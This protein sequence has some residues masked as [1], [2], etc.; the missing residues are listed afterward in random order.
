[1]ANRI[2]PNN[3]VVGQRFGKLVV[4]VAPPTQKITEDCLCQCE[5]G[6]VKKFRV[7]NLIGGMSTSCGCTHSG[8]RSCN[9]LGRKFGRLTVVGQSFRQG[10]RRVWPCSCE[11]G[12][13]AYVITNKLLSGWTH[14][15]GCLS[16]EITSHINL[17][18]GCAKNGN[19]TPEYRLWL[20]AKRRAQQ[21]DVPFTIK[22]SDVKIPDKCPLLEIPLVVGSKGHNPN[23][24]SVDEVVPGQGYTPSNFQIISWRANTI[25]NTATVEELELLVSNL[26]LQRER[27]SERTS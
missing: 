12:K 14:S 10:K 18:H 1:M 5:C 13:T 19:L 3:I 25:K 11:C 8:W 24:V 21:K 9:L 7:H 4:T 17:K 16:S 22:I 2:R 23:N 20:N 26:R 6:T 27:L 15:C